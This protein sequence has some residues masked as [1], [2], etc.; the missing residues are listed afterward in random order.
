MANLRLRLPLSFHH[1]G[2]KKF[3]RSRNISIPST[4]TTRSTHDE[5]SSMSNGRLDGKVAIVTGAGRGMGESHALRF[6]KEGARVVMTDV[7]LD[8]IEKMAAKCEGT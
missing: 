2:R 4:P 7:N 8:A 6:A 1:Q 3:S 5:E